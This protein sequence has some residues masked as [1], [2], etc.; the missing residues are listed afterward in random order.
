MH[1]SSQQIRPVT[2]SYD[3]QKETLDAEE[4]AEE[5]VEEETKDA[6]AESSNENEGRVGMQRW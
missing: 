4:E 6:K 2:I 5:E 1:S 3:H